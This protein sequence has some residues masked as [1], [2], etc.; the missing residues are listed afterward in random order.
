[1]MGGRTDSRR[2]PRSP[3][4]QSE[5]GEH[6]HAARR[7]RYRGGGRYAGGLADLDGR[8]GRMFADRTERIVLGFAALVAGMGCLLVAMGGL[9]LLLCR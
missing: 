4:G 6:E 9:Q 1:M 5:G 7:A 3:P 8:T 2:R